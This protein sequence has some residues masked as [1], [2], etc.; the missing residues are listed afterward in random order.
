MTSDCGDLRVALG[1]Y[2]VRAL[3][4][5]ERTQVEDHLAGCARC[6]EEVA[7]LAVLPGLLGRLSQAEAITAGGSRRPSIL[8][9]STLTE[10]TL[11]RRRRRRRA[12]LAAVAAAV[13]IAAGGGGI[14]MALHLTPPASPAAAG[15][16]WSGV[17]PTT[18]VLATALVGAQPWGSAIHLVLSGVPAGEHCRL[19]AVARDG[20]RENA[21]GWRASYTGQAAIDA[22]TAIAAD[23]LAALQVVSASGSALVSLRP[24][25]GAGHNGG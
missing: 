10:L 7:R 24:R 4:P 8:L 9:E 12:R 22:T 25:A 23:Q 5:A 14:A 3:D 2:V 21:G 16:R 11:R 19:V 15:E 13:A 17:D 18:G 1:P 20:T 6:R